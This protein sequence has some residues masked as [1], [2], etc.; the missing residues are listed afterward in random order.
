M[1]MVG[2][3]GKDESATEGWD[4]LVDDVRIYG[5]VLTAEEIGEVM[6]GIPPGVASNPSPADKATDVP[7]DA[8]LNWTPGE[9]A[10]PI[11]GHKVYISENFNDVNDGVGGIAQDASSYVPGRLDFS[12]TYYWRVD[13]VNGPPDHTV[14]EGGVWSF[15]TEPIA[16]LIQNIIVTASSSAAATGPENTVNGSG[17][18]DS[19][20]LHGNMSA[21]TMWL[22]AKE[23]PQPSWI[24]F[25][26]DKVYKLYELWVWNSNSSLEPMIG[27]GLKDVSIEYSVDG[28]DYTTLGTTH[29]FARAPGTPGYAHDT[30]IGFGGVAVKYVMLTA[31][32]NWG[33][34]LPQYGLSEVR[35]LYIPVQ[36]REP[37]PDSGATDVDVDAVLSWRA[38]RE[39]ASHEVYFSTD[40][41]AVI[42]G[43]APVATVAETRHGPLS[44]DLDVTHYWKVNEVNE[45][46]TPSTWQGG[47][48][49]FT[50]ND[51]IVVDDFENYNDLDPT[52]PASNRIF[53]VWIDGFGIATNGSLVGYDAPPF[54]EQSIVHS[55]NQSM[56]LFYDNSG[57]ARYSEAELTLNPAQDWT[58]YGVKA[59]SLW[60]HGD[61]NNAAEQMYVK[62]NGSKVVYDG[63]AADI[64]Q[65]SWQDWSIDLAL[66]GASLQ[67]VTKISIGLG[68]EA[69]TTPG[70]SGKMLFDDIRLYPS[71][72]ILSVMSFNIR[73]G[74]AND[75]ENHW[76]NRREMVFDVFR[77]HHPDIVG[78]QE[79]LDFQIAEIR[80][81]L[82]KYGQIGVAREDGKTEGEYSV[83]LYRLDRFDV[84]ESE[85]FWL[86]DTPEVPGSSHWGNARV[87]ICT[88]ARFVEKK[89][90]KAFYL[91][92]T[93]LD[94]VS[95]PS[96]EKSAV[97]LAQRIRDRRHPDPFVVTGDFNAGEDNPVVTY[98]KGMT[99]LGGPDGRESSSSVP[100]VDT[101]RV[102]HP[103]IKDVRTGHGF[104]GSRQG[105]KIDYVL[106]PPDVKV[107]EAQILYDNVDGRYPSDHFPVTARLRL[108]VA[109]ER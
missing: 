61:P 98:L 19:G 75:G 67:N 53:S 94:H 89:S 95:Q 92:N 6:K 2:K 25:Q 91:Y 36:A 14:Y 8:V 7:R 57:T 64:R 12:T 85:T 27:F 34:I 46:E 28:T 4:G 40:E 29:Q 3:G 55:D 80:R 56:P 45:A 54:A 66:F 11:N 81:A 20:L 107:L 87:R 31:N 108:P 50:T 38:G 83:I 21:D 22:S 76:N 10:P 109:G 15:T 84:D 41:Q 69:G 16:Y 32:S 24:E 79:A 9:Y 1:V 39:A 5:R 44:L 72:C 33:G 82:T 43:T 88:W 47:L 26:F 51:H 77:N 97:L 23:G 78:L 105:N 49:S 102:L 62:V 74:S 65:A 48:W 35:F 42:D 103:H 17:L 96:R 52:D 86:S 90:G 70:G 60:F 59:L 101:F 71:R 93:H 73:Y 68:D 30:T 37:N 99:S 100:M 13:E 63:D 58:K 18:D 106:A 104:R